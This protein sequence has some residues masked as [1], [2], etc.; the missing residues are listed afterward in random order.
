MSL[1]YIVAG[2]FGQAVELTF[3]DVDTG[4]VADISAFVTAQKMLFESPSGTATTKTAAF[5]T[6][7]TD[8]IISYTV[9]SDFL[10]VG[11]W[12]VK[13]RVELG[14][15]ITRRLTTVEHVFEVIS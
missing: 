8:G 9:E 3:I 12:R 4:L 1:K 13:G 5:K 7:G 2:D 6:D 15:P 11:K 10:T 14:D